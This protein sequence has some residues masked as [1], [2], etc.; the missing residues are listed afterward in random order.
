MVGRHLCKELPKSS[1]ASGITSVT[2]RAQCACPGRRLFVS[3][4]NYAEARHER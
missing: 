4:A 2:E 1:Q 3:S